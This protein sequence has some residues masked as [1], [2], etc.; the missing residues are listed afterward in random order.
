MKRWYNRRQL[1]EGNL[2]IL[3]EIICEIIRSICSLC[4]TYWKLV[5]VV[6]F[7]KVN[8]VIFI[9]FSFIYCLWNP[10]QKIKIYQRWTI[11]KLNATYLWGR[12]TESCN[13]NQI[14]YQEMSSLTALTWQI[15]MERAF[16]TKYTIKRQIFSNFYYEDVKLYENIH[17]I[18]VWFTMFSSSLVSR[19]IV[20]A[21]QA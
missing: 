14:I 4:G 13:H 18:Y 10:A 9:K 12:R 1:I 17:F 21:F 3:G 15:G 20:K 11:Y 6:N 19:C 2:P 16:Y 5:N 8:L 7:I